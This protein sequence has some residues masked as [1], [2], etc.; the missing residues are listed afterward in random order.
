LGA[1]HANDERLGDS[2]ASNGELITDKAAVIVTS[3][4]FSE[5]RYIP[6]LATSQIRKYRYSPQKIA[7]VCHGLQRS[8]EQLKSP[9]P[10]GNME[11]FGS[12]CGGFS[13]Q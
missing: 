12:F 1:S 10:M 5:G 2:G 4:P 3:K 9:Y 7:I 13:A 11:F 8:L 6:F